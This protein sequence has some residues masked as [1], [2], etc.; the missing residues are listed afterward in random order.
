MKK[1]MLALEQNETLDFD[2]LSLEKNSWMSLVV[3]CEA[4]F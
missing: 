4:E 1:E 2:V 3:Y